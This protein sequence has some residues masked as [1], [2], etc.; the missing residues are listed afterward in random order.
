GFNST[1]ALELRERNSRVLTGLAI[2]VARFDGLDISMAVRASGLRGAAGAVAGIFFLDDFGRPL[3]GNEDGS[4]A[5]S[6]SDSFD[7]RLDRA[8]VR[9]PPCARRAV[10]QIKKN[11]GFGMIRFDDVRI[12]QSPD[13][14]AGS[15]TPFQ[16]ADDTED[17]LEVAPS[18]GITARSAL[19]VSF[20]LQAPAGA[21][22]PVTVKNGRLTFGGSDRARFFGVYLLPPAAFPEEEV[23]DELA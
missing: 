16:V 15:W 3:A 22:G 4:F 17:W 18:K 5:F 13:P 1:A 21:R 20:L 11:D 7:W 9:V 12:T 14:E 23:A 6:W 2:E 19:D 8:F 10:L